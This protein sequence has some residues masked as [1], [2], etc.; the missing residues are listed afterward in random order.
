MVMKLACE[1]LSRSLSLS[2]SLQEKSQSLREWWLGWGRVRTGVS[3]CPA[4]CFLAEHVD[5]VKERPYYIRIKHYLVRS[6][7][8]C[9]LDSAEPQG[10]GSAHKWLTDLLRY[11]IQQLSHTHPI[12]EPI[13]FRSST[14][15][16]L[17]LAS[18]KSFQSRLFFPKKSMKWK[19][20]NEER[21]RAIKNRFIAHC[22]ALF[23]S[24]WWSVYSCSPRGFN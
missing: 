17:P 22:P 13:V 8:T 18:V 5:S 21:S 20:N 19:L 7:A 1:A 23:C 9:T 10:L 16:P 11:I 4:G 6:R 3:I 2:Q 15:P 14:D 12:Y 24:G